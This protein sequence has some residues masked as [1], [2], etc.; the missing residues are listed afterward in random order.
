CRDDSSALKQDRPQRAQRIEDIDMSK[1]RTVV[2][3]DSQWQQANKVLRDPKVAQLPH[4]KSDAQKTY[5]WR[6]QRLG[7][8]APATIEGADMYRLIQSHYRAD[9]TRNFQRKKDYIKY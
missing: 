5:F 6:Y 9:R 4:V 7:D 3:V 1:V 8:E 2:F